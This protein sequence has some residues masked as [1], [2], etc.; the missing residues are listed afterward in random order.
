MRR[1]PW[2]VIAQAIGAALVVVGVVLAFGPAAALIAAGIAVLAFGI[3][4]ER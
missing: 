3:A 2:A 1:I 4:G